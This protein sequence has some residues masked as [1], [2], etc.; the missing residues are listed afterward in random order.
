MWRQLC[1][2]PIL[3][4]L[5]RCDALTQTISAQCAAAQP[6]VVTIGDL[7]VHPSPPEVVID[8]VRRMFKKQAAVSDHSGISSVALALYYSIVV[9]APRAVTKLTKAELA[10]GLRWALSQTW[11]DNRTRELLTTASERQNQE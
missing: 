2:A 1:A 9:A 3:A 7:L 4:E 5:D 11:L 8:A 6:P 10:E